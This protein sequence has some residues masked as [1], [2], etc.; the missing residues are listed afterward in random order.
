MD[1]WLVGSLTVEPKLI[2]WRVGAFAIT[3]SIGRVRTEPLQRTRW[4]RA[5]NQRWTVAVTLLPWVSLQMSTVHFVW[6]YNVSLIV[7]MC[8]N[9]LLKCSQSSF[10]SSRCHFVLIYF[11]MILYP[12]SGAS[13]SRGYLLT[14]DAIP[15]PVGVLICK[16]LKI[17]N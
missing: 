8:N 9:K 11:R 14:M 1:V 17:A 4:C 13:I 12:L 3:G 7:K 6:H 2:V 15:W 10:I 16:V 5:R